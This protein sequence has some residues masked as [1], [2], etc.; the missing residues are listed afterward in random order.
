MLVSIRSHRRTLTAGQLALY[1]NG[2]LATCGNPKN[3]FDIDLTKRLRHFQSTDSEFEYALVSLSLCNARKRLAKKRIIHLLN[4]LR[5][6]TDFHFWADTQ[7]V[8]V[9]ALSC[10]GKH[11]AYAFLENHIYE[12][13]KSF[14]KRQQRNGSFGNVYTTGLIVQALLAAGDDGVGWDFNQAVRY[15]LSQQEPG[16]SFGD[17][18]ATYFVLPILSCQNYVNLGEVNCT[19]P[20]PLN[21]TVNENF[22]LLGEPEVND[23]NWSK[24]IEVRY[25]LWIGDN[26]EENYSVNLNTSSDTK[27]LDVMKHSANYN[28]VYKFELDETSW[29]PFVYKIAGMANDPAGQRFWILYIENP[30]THELHFSENGVGKLYLQNEDHVVFWYKTVLNFI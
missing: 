11:E 5:S 24:E 4:Q 13:L 25:S 30:D 6:T 16:G 12:A 1:V 2:I 17:T 8:A 9:M 15:L 19:E 7:A 10:V 20:I 14:K 28:P 27:F 18:L 23:V 22:T 29:G 21:D 26:K 3:F